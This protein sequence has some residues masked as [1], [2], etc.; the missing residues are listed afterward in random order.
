MKIYVSLLFSFLL[1]S[2]I[3]FE[4]KSEHKNKVSNVPKIELDRYI[5]SGTRGLQIS[6]LLSYTDK[7][8]AIKLTVKKIKGFWSLVFS[9]N[10]V[11]P[12]VEIHITPSQTA[13]F[14]F[15]DAKYTVIRGRRSFDILGKRYKI[16]NIDSSLFRY[17]KKS[18][19]YIFNFYVYKNLRFSKAEVS[20]LKLE[21]YVGS[22]KNDFD[23]ISEFMMYPLGGRIPNVIKNMEGTPVKWKW[24]WYEN[25]KTGSIIWHILSYNKTQFKN[26]DFKATNSKMKKISLKVFLNDYSVPLHNDTLFMV[27]LKGSKKL[28]LVYEDNSLR[29]V[30]PP[31]EQTGLINSDTNEIRVFPLLGGTV[32]MDEYLKPPLTW[33][34]R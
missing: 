31:N 17:D 28:G 12:G 18:K 5:P 19:K 24:T 25:G 13:L 29:G 11:F 10:G 15:S 34:L 1:T 22:S 30:L 2:C 20:R 26:S 14:D 4:K 16:E 21:C 3:F 7:T 8:E 6:A 23:L 9:P 27:T 33:S 32:L